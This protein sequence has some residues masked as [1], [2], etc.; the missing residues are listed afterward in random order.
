MQNDKTKSV[1]DKTTPTDFFLNELNIYQPDFP[2]LDKTEY[3]CNKCCHI[4]FII[5]IALVIALV[6]S[7]TGFGIYFGLYH[8]RNATQTTTQPITPM[9]TILDFT[10]TATITTTRTTVKPL[11]C[12]NFGSLNQWLCVFR[13]QNDFF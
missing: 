13:C 7:G 1:D 12:I 11:E 10:T 6:V 2:K 8:N 3:R 5:L 4:W 9:P